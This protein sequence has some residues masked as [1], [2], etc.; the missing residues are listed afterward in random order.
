M[1][2]A[3]IFMLATLL[4]STHSNRYIDFRK[5]KQSIYV[6]WALVILSLITI[7]VDNH[8]LDKQ[9]FNRILF[10][11]S[12]GYDT[13]LPREYTPVWAINL[14]KTLKESA[15]KRVATISGDAVTRI[16]LW[17]PEKRTIRVE[18]YS[19]SLLRIAT[20]Y[21][22]GWQAKIDGV[23]THV[24][25]EKMS[26]A[27][28]LKVMPGKHLITLEFNDTPLRKVSKLVSLISL[29]ILCIIVYR[30][31]KPVTLTNQISH[32]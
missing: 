9:L 18:A 20:F 6:L 21:Y 8:I 28:L 5:C 17:N 29:F 25:T 10:P 7:F 16:E 27:M 2:I 26:G 3:L 32:T 30:T 12:H 31:Q 4:D 23:A 15:P 22:P 19:S 24:L 14:E 11:E 13:S 1:E